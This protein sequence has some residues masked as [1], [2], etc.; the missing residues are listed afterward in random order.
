M[1]FL[2]PYITLKSIDNFLSHVFKILYHLFARILLLQQIT[3]PPPGG[4]T[5]LNNV[6]EGCDI[7]SKKGQLRGM[8]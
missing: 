2:I 6:K 1:P 5:S 7:W 4:P 3:T 8:A